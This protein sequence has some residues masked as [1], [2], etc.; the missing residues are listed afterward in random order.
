MAS[1][2]A[3]VEAQFR[4]PSIATLAADNSEEA[5]A[6]PP[7]AP[8]ATLLRAPGVGVAD[9]VAE[10]VGEGVA[11]GVGVA[12]GVGV[13]VGVG[14]GVDEGVGVAEG[15]GVGGGLF[16]PLQASSSTILL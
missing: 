1:F 6:V 15:V 16:P 10:G 9:G 4:T 8:S 13:A 12:E 11:G 2:H 5:E 7:F 14:V 3:P